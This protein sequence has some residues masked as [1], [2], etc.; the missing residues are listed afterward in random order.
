MQVLLI[1]CPATS[2]GK[3]DLFKHVGDIGVLKVGSDCSCPPE[4]Q[5]CCS[6]HGFGIYQS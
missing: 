3:V 4:F 6:S 2:F 1:P 5:G